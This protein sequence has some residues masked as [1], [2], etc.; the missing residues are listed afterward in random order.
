M[1]R[2]LG[3]A[4]WVSFCLNTSCGSLG[5]GGI[6]FFEND[7][8]HKA[9]AI[10]P[11]DGFLVKEFQPE[12]PPSP[13]NPPVSGPD[14]V[15]PIVFILSPSY[16]GEDVSNTILLQAKALDDVGVESVS[17]LVDGQVIDTD[18]TA[19]Y[20]ISLD[21]KIFVDR[22]SHLVI[23]KAR[24][25]SGNE[26]TSASRKIDVDNSLNLRQGLRK[27]D[28]P[29]VP[30]APFGA[31]F[32]TICAFSHGSYND[33][34]VF[35]GQ[36]GHSHLHLFFGNDAIDEFSTNVSIRTSGGSTCQG[37][38]LNRSSYWV[39]ALFDA[40]GNVVHP[41][42]ANIY[43][44]HGAVDHRLIEAMPV[45]LR[46]IS[47][48][49]KATEPQSV[50]INQFN[51]LSKPITSSKDF[52]SF[53]PSCAQGD[54]LMWSVI[55][56]QC[57]DGVNLDSADHK[58]H[59]A[60][61]V[62]D[63][64]TKISICP[65][66]HPVPLPRITFQFKFPV[67][68]PEGT[69]GWRISSDVDPLSPGGMTGHADW[70]NGWD[71]EIVRTFVTKCLNAGLDCT[72]GELGDGTQLVGF[73]HGRGTIESPP[74]SSPPPPPP[75]PAPD[76]N[77]TPVNFK[78]AFTG[79]MNGT[80]GGE[81]LL[82]LIHDE[83][84]D[85]LM[86]Q[87]D[88]NY[89]NDPGEWE[90]LIDQ[91]LGSDFPLLIS[92]GHHDVPWDTYFSKMQSRI[93]RISGLTCSGGLGVNQ[94]CDYRGMRFVL[95]GAG[96]AGTDHTSYIRNAFAASA[97]MW[98]ICSMH[99]NLDSYKASINLPQEECRNAGAI[100]ATAHN[101][102]YARSYLFDNL[103]ARHVV[104]TNN[105]MHIDYGQTFGFISG[106][107]GRSVEFL[108]NQ[109]LGQEAWFAANYGTL[110]NG[111]FGAL[112]CEF[113]KDGVA[114]EAA[115]YFKD[116]D[117][118]IA[119]SF[120]LV[121]DVVPGQGL[122]PETTPVP[123]PPPVPQPEPTPV[124]S[125]KPIPAPVPEPSP[126]PTPEP[127]PEPAPD[128]E[129]TPTQQPPLGVNLGT[130][131]YWSPEWVVLDG[132][133]SSGGWYTQ[134]NKYRPDGNPSSC[135]ASGWDTKEQAKLDLDADGW[136]KSLPAIDDANA[137]YRYASAFI[138]GHIKGAH[139]PGGQ[140]I[141]LYDGEGVIEYEMDAVKN[142]AASSLGRDVIDVRPNAGILLRIRKTDP[143]HTGNY[144]R[145]IRVLPPGGTCDGDSL[146]FHADASS[147]SG[148]FSSFEENYATQIFHPL[149]LQKIAK[150][151]TLRFLHF[152]QVNEMFIQEWDQ[153][154]LISDAR[155][156]DSY[157]GAPPEVMIEMANK[158]G[159][160][161]WIEMQHAAS[162]D[163]VRQYAL[164]TKSL[165]GSQQKVYLEYGNEVW[166]GAYPYSIGGNYMTQK[167]LQQW[168]QQTDPNIAK[169]NWFAKRTV[170]MCNIWKQVFTGEESRVV[171]VMGSQAASIGVSNQELSC[172]L[173]AAENGGKTCGSQ[174][175]ALAI[176][177]YFGFM[178]DTGNV[179]AV[180]SW[181]ADADGG[182]DKVFQELF[183]GG[184][185][186][187]AQAPVPPGG[188]PATL[189][190]AFQYMDR[191][192]QVAA[193]HGVDLLAYEGGQHLVV[194]GAILDD[195]YKDVHDLLAN[196]NRDPRMGQLYTQYLNGWKARGGELF[197]LFDS[198]GTYGKHGYWGLLEYQDQPGSAKY[199]AVMDFIDENPIWF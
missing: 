194:R 185:L 50:G 80:V 132:M 100:L 146:S 85:L 163:F 145:N 98:R 141:V 109:W 101:H 192:F 89:N 105:T 96:I 171:C 58:S 93:S 131:G 173:Y 121:S 199:N 72:N 108:K 19:P 160:D 21:T 33:P 81:A 106:L 139:Y 5:E 103:A 47:G 90:R 164:L 78:I 45:G 189:Q 9:I 61:P 111:N 22:T 116:I 124:P 177:P 137:A 161:P 55:F 31:N 167:G 176:A 186:N 183:A 162:D 26:T 4:L 144:I 182:V 53:I 104:S 39:P 77:A 153:R 99:N 184:L 46:M 51:C 16:H 150:F 123:E 190:V 49:G 133:K 174:I 198:V 92:M 129:P 135:P 94:T 136:V 118:N 79:D 42:P 125:P 32:R 157:K 68:V 170:E 11:I 84:T 148:V 43:Y 7:V 27:A 178:V 83:G 74:V 70:F 181:M 175:D 3:L 113:N 158:T 41:K 142:V 179:A 196:V 57:W 126:A 73:L 10:D 97:S 23:V 143:N 17:F 130:F 110:Q 87:G 147:C 168:P 66:S 28:R 75:P 1:K 122:P 44:K 60:Q 187:S 40:D 24:D 62:H 29:F 8:D 107:G 149:F 120:R 36:G 82:Q 140:Y 67:T 30:A 25:T 195:Q 156:S 52:S 64:I 112:F 35:P 86:I 165:L 13:L 71:D 12:A 2:I 20:E 128:P 166:N 115:C 95:S 102:V 188:I 6:D 69:T 76:P 119:D 127:Q 191:S 151:K 138:H 134:C 88:L 65:A 37:G 154:T 117:G 152:T 38:T 193:A 59:M 180:R 63:P 14:I 15:A 91:Y 169:L 54:T 197:V 56:P 114:N 155:W 34:I 18:T 48:N 159:A 172:P